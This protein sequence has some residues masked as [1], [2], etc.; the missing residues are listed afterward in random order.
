LTN[1]ARHAGVTK[2]RL[3]VW[4]GPRSLGA[5]IEDQGRGFVVE[6]ALAGHSS[7]L[8]GMRERCRLLGGQLTIESTPEA[9]T[10]LSIEL[11]LSDRPA[12]GSET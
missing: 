7:G 9:G 8:A 12:T 2:A 5:R 3:Q 6:T 10:R 4:A 1:V 11:P